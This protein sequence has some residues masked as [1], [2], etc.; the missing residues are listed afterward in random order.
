MRL[1]RDKV[2]VYSDCLSEKTYFLSF[3]EENNMLNVLFDET[4]IYCESK[5]KYNMAF[6]NISSHIAT[7][8][9]FFHT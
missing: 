9:L 6:T 8:S 3:K 1:G 2:K 5:L 4:W 7:L